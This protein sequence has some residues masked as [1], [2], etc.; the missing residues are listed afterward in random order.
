MHTGKGGNITTAL[1]ALEQLRDEQVRITQGESRGRSWRDWLNLSTWKAQLL[2]IEI[3]VGLILL[4]L[5]MGDLENYELF[6]SRLY[7]AEN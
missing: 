2:K 5:V 3:G 4:V 7:Y 6:C 1:D